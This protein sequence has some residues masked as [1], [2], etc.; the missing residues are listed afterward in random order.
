MSTEKKIPVFV[1]GT[2]R[3]GQYNH[4]FLKDA[5]YLADGVTE[6]KYGMYAHA[7]PMVTRDM[8]DVQIKGELY[9]VTKEEFKHLDRLEGY[10]TFY[11]REK[12]SVVTDNTVIEAWMYFLDDVKNKHEGMYYI[13]SG[14]YVDYKNKCLA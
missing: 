7:Y 12:I 8:Q 9:L 1:Y 5:H 4:Y 6:N 14:D 10:P 3:K 13:A 2:L 11:D